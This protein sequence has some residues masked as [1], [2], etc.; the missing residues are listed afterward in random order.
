MSALVYIG[1]S[2]DN[3]IARPDGDIS[4]LESFASEEVV[5]PYEDIMRRTDAL[6]MG[7]NTFEKVLGFGSWPYARKVFV[8]SS[9]LQTVPEELTGK[10]EIINLSPREALDHLAA[11]GFHHVYVD[12][13]QV[14]QAFLREDLVDE[15]ILS[16]VPLLLG[17][18][19][20]LFAGL[21]RELLFRL[22]AT[23]TFPNG[24]LTTY[25][26]RIR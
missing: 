5:A 10:A 24:L 17:A 11:Q 3:F 22:T 23:R 25:Y 20:P 26:E 21:D 18:G 13:G 1:T 15:L 4:W 6:L 7:R 2:L 9:R 16:R 14:I 19:I 12:G 8:L